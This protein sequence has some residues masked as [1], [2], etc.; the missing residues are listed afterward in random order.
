[1]LAD[2]VYVLTNGSADGKVI[3]LHRIDLPCPARR[4]R[5]PGYQPCQF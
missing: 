1:M 4:R 3:D 2:R 5:H